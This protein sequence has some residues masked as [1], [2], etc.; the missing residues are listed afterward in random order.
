[1]PRL[2]DRHPTLADVARAA[3]VS[4][5]TV[6]RCLNAP[7]RVSAATRAAVMAAVQG[8]GYAPNHAAQSLAASRSDTFGVIIPTMDNAVFA[9]G[10][11]TFQETL[12][13]AG[14]NLLIASSAYDAA[15]EAAQIR[16]LV[17]RGADALLLIGYARDPAIYAYLARRRVPTL[18]AWA[19]AAEAPCPAVGFDNER[20]MRAMTGAVLARGHRRLAMISARTADNDRAAERVAGFRAESRAA[21]IDPATLPVVETV[22]SIADG[23]AA[24]ADL[25]ARAD[26]PTAILCG[27]DVLAMGALMAARDLGLAVPGELSITGFDDIELAEVAVPSLATVHVPHRQM[28]RRAAETLLAMARDGATPDSVALPTRLCLRDSLGPPPA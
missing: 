3:G 13:A 23:R 17:A 25:L 4:T 19:W 2:R 12:G 8:L 16:T 9:R 15:E 14:V 26:R 1:M 6:S 28:G 18:V 21:G 11:Q 22:Y 24:A 20:A 7:E 5:A 27:N 10:I